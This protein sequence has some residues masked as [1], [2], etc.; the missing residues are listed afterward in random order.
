MYYFVNKENVVRFAHVTFDF[1]S[2]Y[3]FVL[4]F[5]MK[6]KDAKYKSH[7]NVLVF[8]KQRKMWT[9]FKKFH[10]QISDFVSFP[11]FHFH[12][13][14]FIFVAKLRDFGFESHSNTL[15]VFDEETL[16]FIVI[17]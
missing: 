12:W 8:Y 5:A 7:R 13:F 11:L 16:N 15:I 14:G 10:E 17:V 2:L 3:F 1:I 6:S 9:N 4:T